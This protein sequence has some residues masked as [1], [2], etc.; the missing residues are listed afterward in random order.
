M[1]E[2]M[3]I[4]YIYPCQ[5]KNNVMS[6]FMLR[7]TIPTGQAVSF[8]F[9]WVI[10]ILLITSTFLLDLVEPLVNYNGRTLYVGKRRK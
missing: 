3:S 10:S 7:G 6:S 1:L 2:T 9:V 5:S 8:F 4:K